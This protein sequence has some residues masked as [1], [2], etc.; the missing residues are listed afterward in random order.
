LIRDFLFSGV[1]FDQWICFSEKAIK[2]DKIRVSSIARPDGRARCAYRLIDKAFRQLE[3][4]YSRGDAIAAMQDSV[5]QMAELLQLKQSTLASVQLEKDVRAMYERLDLN[6]LY[7]SLTLLA[8][9]VSLRYPQ[10]DLLRVLALIGHAGEDALLDQVARACGDTTREMAAH[11]KFPKVYDALVE[12][13]VAPAEKRPVLLKKYV[14]GW[15]KRM[16]PI[17]W[18]GNHEAAEGAYFGYWSFEAALVAML[19]DVDDSAFAE[20]PNYPGD[21]MRHVRGAV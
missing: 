12:V 10:E 20:H 8:F 9:V 21:L 5:R 4:R 15:Y 11:S 13:I 2:E 3:R 7:E 14:E 17:S 18:H 19:F 16:K 6:A 1:Y